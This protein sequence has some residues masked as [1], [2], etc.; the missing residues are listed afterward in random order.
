MHRKPK[1]TLGRGHIPGYCLF[2]T[3]GRDFCML[4]NHTLHFEILDVCIMPLHVFFYLKHFCCF[5]PLEFWYVIVPNVI[6]F[7]SASNQIHS[8]SFLTKLHHPYCHS[9]HFLLFQC[10][11]NS[12]QEQA[13]RQYSSLQSGLVQISSS[14]PFSSTLIDTWYR[15]ILYSF[16]RKCWGQEFCKSNKY[17]AAVWWLSLRN[18]VLQCLHC[19]RHHWRPLSSARQGLVSSVFRNKNKICCHYCTQ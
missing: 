7:R 10:V 8:L 16:D 17:K 3:L 2:T 9:P 5:F 18:F 14:F 1:Q 11:S 6:S 19:R 15:Q 4:Q 12:L 13:L